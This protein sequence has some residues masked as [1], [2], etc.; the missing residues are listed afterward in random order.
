MGAQKTGK[1]K[2]AEGKKTSRALMSPADKKARE[3]KMLAIAALAQKADV[4][5]LKQVATR[6]ESTG[7]VDK[8]DLVGVPFFV[9]GVDRRKSDYEKGFYL[10]VT[11]LLEKTKE[12]VVFNDGG[13]GIE[14]ALEGV[15]IDPTAN[16]PKVM[17][18]P[19]GLRASNYTNEHGP[20][21]TYYFSGRKA[22][23]DIAGLNGQAAGKARGRR[24]DQQQD[25]VSF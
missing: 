3:A 6:V 21:T 10:S 2:A 8:E 19:D 13:V 9:V 1:G 11:C 24:A 4:E 16:P 17:Y 22:K 18:V 5:K 15:E 23:E 25:D 7:L 20:A 12:V 14:Q